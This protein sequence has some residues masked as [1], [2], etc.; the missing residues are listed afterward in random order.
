MGAQE[1][2][3][4]AEILSQRFL[5]DLVGIDEIRLALR[6]PDGHARGSEQVLILRV[7]AIEK[8]DNPKFPLREATYNLTF[9]NV[10]GFRL[11]LPLALEETSLEMD[12]DDITLEERHSGVSTLKFE[13]ASSTIEID[14]RMVDR[15][16]VHVKECER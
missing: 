3:T 1:K 6:T 15:T 9:K 8:N 2:K 4:I 5:I 14:F 7:L 16:L 12:V 13:N 11:D 10:T